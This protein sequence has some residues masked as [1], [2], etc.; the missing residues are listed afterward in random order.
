MSSGGANHSVQDPNE[1]CAWESQKIWV[2]EKKR[3]KQILIEG[4]RGTRNRLG[5]FYPLFY[6]IA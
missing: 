6:L 1:S 5:D 4:L 2:L 3:E